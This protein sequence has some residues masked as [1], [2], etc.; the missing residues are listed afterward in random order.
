MAQ[1]QNTTKFLLAKLQVS[2]NSYTKMVDSAYLSKQDHDIFN[3]ANKNQKNNV[4]SNALIYFN[5]KCEI[6]RL[7]NNANQRAKQAEEFY[8]DYKIESLISRLNCAIQNLSK[9]NHLVTKD[10]LA[11]CKRLIALRD[12]KKLYAEVNHYE[13]MLNIFLHRRMHRVIQARKNK[14]FL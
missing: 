7:Q 14:D 12:D 1:H 9:E 11:E 3:H 10:N 2:F 8:K 13:T 6:Q 4:I 5:S